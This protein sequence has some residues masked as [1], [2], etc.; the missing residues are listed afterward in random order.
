MSFLPNTMPMALS[1]LGVVVALV[2]IFSPKATEDKDGLGEIDLAQLKE[3][4]IAQA[5]G[6]VGAMVLYALLLRPIGFVAATSLFIVGTSVILG[7]RK[8]HLLV[9]IAV[10]TAGVIWY[11]VQ[12]TLGIFLRPWP[13]FLS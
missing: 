6:I 13:A 4:K 1:V 8:F 9:P 11:L 10:L 7:E 12:E 2:I 5:L 3:F